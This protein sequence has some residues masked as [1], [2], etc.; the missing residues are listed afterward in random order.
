[1]ED[2]GDWLPQRPCCTP[3]RGDPLAPEARRSHQHPEFTSLQQRRSDSISEV[4]AGLQCLRRN[5]NLE[6]STLEVFVNLACFLGVCDAT[7]PRPNA[8]DT[9]IQ[10]VLT[11]LLVGV[12]SVKRLS[13]LPNLSA[14]FLQV[15]HTAR[16][17]NERRCVIT[18]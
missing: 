12:N 17:E 4:F 6:T 9:S 8:A 15:I 10:R 11:V 14:P 3:L 16:Q 7:H 1:M 2:R 5:E 18:Q 13:R